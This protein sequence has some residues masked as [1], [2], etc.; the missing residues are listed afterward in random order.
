MQARECA[1][2]RCFG[3][4]L[5][6]F[7]PHLPLWALFPSHICP[8]KARNEVTT[9]FVTLLTITAFIGQVLYN[10]LIYNALQFIFGF[11][12]GK[13]IFSEGGGGEKFRFPMVHRRPR[14]RGVPK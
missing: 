14:G 3:R 10:L 8:F 6:C 13:N 1:Y 9:R 4:L 7:V 2:T 12:T 11:E 5:P